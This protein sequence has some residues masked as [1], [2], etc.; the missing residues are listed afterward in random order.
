MRLRTLVPIAAA[1]L[2][3]AAPARADKTYTDPAGDGGTAHDLT[4]VTVSNDAT[5]V[6]LRFPVPNPWPNLRP[7]DDQAWLLMIDADRNPSTGDRGQEVRVFERSGAQVYIW[8]GSTWVDAPPQGI[9]VR[10]ELS[11]S[12]AAWRVQLPRTLLGGTTGFDFQ[13]ASA[14]WVGEDIAATDL[15]PDGG[16]WRYELALTQCANGQDDD[17]DGKI[18]AT[19]RGCTGT[20]DD[21]EGDEPVTPR[22]LRPTVTPART[23]PGRPVLVRASARQL[24]TGTPLATGAVVCTIRTGSTQKRVTGRISAGLATCR[25]TAPRVARPTTV[26]GSMAIV[27]TTQSL[28]FSFRVG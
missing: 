17:H 27:G 23:T 19:D 2:V 26:R 8:N 21:A 16:S 25:L 5:Q 24:E 10:F 28:P 13:L 22:L 14:K 11:S 7:P 4:T 12:S 9:S 20:N 15:A 1:A 18:D 3:L 6:V